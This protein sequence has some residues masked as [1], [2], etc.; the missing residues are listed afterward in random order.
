MKIILHGMMHQLI[1][2]LGEH[3]SQLYPLHIYAIAVETKEQDVFLLSSWILGKCITY[4]E[5]FVMEDLKT[6]YSTPIFNY[7][8]CK[9]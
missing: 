4:E 6:L 3:T 5:P 2:A 1:V 9:G 8:I 7:N